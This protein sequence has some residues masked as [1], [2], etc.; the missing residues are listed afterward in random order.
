MNPHFRRFSLVAI[1]LLLATAAC[2][3]T[4]VSS[5]PPSVTITAPVNPPRYVDGD[6]IT[7][8]GSAVDPEDGPLTGASLIWKSS[9]DGTLGNGET[10]T[11]A[12]ID[13]T[14]GSHTITLAAIDSEG[15]TGSAS[16]SVLV[17][18]PPS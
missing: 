17:G 2:D 16:I 10:I 3:P 7:F 12:A 11:V 13:L 14:V 5:K 15:V 8:E 4:G 6:T 9:L 1:A 18:E